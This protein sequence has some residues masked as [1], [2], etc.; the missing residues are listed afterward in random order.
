VIISEGVC[1]GWIDMM[2]SQSALAPA[3]PDERSSRAAYFRLIGTCFL[4]T[5]IPATVDLLTNG[6][7]PSMFYVVPLVLLGKAGQRRLL[8]PF[9][10]LLL[11]LTFGLWLLDH[12][13]EL[14][15]DPRELLHWRLANRAMA[16]VAICV[17]CGALHFWLG[18]PERLVLAGNVESDPTMFDEVSESLRNFIGFFVSTLL[19]AFIALADFTTPGQ[20]NLPILYTIPLVIAHWMGSRRLLWL[21]LPVLL[22]IAVLGYTLGEPPHVEYARLPFIIVNRTFAICTLVVLAVCLH[23]LIRPQRNG[24]DVPKVV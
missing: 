19:I 24:A 17:V 20:I 10:V 12:L 6:V 14:R 3:D 11:V 21:L 1:P 23:F 7:N 4:L 2:D 15:T 8:V 13:P 5:A 9:T 16:A 18:L 22:L